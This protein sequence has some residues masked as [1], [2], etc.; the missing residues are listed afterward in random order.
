MKLWSTRLLPAPF[1]GPLSPLPPPSDEGGPLATD[2]PAP[3]ASLPLAPAPRSICTPSPQPCCA[4]PASTPL[5]A[6]MILLLAY[7]EAS[8][9]NGHATNRRLPDVPAEMLST[10]MMLVG[11]PYT[12]SRASCRVRLRSMPPVLASRPSELVRHPRP[13]LHR[14]ILRVA[15]FSP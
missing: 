11:K 14:C 15:E 2:T 5:S 3:F 13:F 9:N 1:F 10:L 12:S 6:T 4:L 7:G 8:L